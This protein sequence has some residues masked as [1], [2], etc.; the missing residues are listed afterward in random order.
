VEIPHQ[1]FLSSRLIHLK[2]NTMLSNFM[3]VMRFKKVVYNEE[4]TLAKKTA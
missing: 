3:P 1:V 4:M 2:D